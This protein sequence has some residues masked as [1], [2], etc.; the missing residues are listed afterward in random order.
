MIE[1]LLLRYLLN[2]QTYSKYY[3]YVTL[4]NKELQK[5]YYVLKPLQE[6]TDKEVSTV[7]D[8]EVKFFTEYPFLKQVEKE[9]YEAIF[10]RLTEV[11]LEDDKLIEYLEKQR[12]MVLARQ[13]AEI[14]LDVT[15][16]R[17]DFTEILDHIE[18]LDLDASI[19]EETIFVNDDLEELYKEQVATPGLK[20]RLNCLNKSLGSLRRGDFGFIFARP[21]TG[22]TTFLASEVTFMASQC[23]GPILWFNNEEQGEKVMLRCIQAS[24]GLT[25]AELY[26]DLAR[27]K[28]KFYAAT[29]RN[30]RIVDNASIHKFDVERICKQMKPS[31]IIFDQIDKIKGFTADRPDLQLGAIY[32]WARELAKTYAPVIGVCQADGTGEGVKWL[33]MGHV[34]NAKTAK[35]AEADWIVGIGRSNEEGL[36]YVRNFNISKN[37]LQ[38]DVES[39]P[40]MRHGQM[41]CIIKPE[42]GRYVDM[43]L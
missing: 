14:A 16:G 22:K 5:I 17:K 13:V 7:T 32:I 2:K 27:G 20:W 25:Q 39:D 36:A 31:L 41:T 26:S 18:G 28:A 37:K 15:E 38:G 4:S 10:S 30:I 34:A 19:E 3:K 42:I 8:L 12:E 9:A 21:E 33:N 23:E 11:E 24:L 40:A 35:Q 6:G 1:L 43:S 29:K